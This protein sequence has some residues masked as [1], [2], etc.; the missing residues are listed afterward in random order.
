MIKVIIFQ[1]LYSLD[2]F[3]KY[4]IT[5]IVDLFE[6]KAM[7]YIIKLLKKLN[8]CILYFVIYI[9]QINIPKTVMLLYL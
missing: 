8:E 7:L 6:T 5:S 2:N 1:L 9:T 3:F 4:Y